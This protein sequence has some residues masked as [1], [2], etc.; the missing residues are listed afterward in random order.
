M[1]SENI[2]RRATFNP[3]VCT[4]W[5][6]SFTIV[7]TVIVVGIPFLLLWIP[8]SLYFTKR[9]LDRME[10]ILT[11]RDLKVNKGL[12]VRV[13]K[14]IPLEKITD[15]GMV[16][17]PLMRYFGI[18]R[19]SVETAGQSLEGSLVS[20][21]GIVDVEDFREAVLNQRDRIRDKP[22]PSVSPPEQSVQGDSGLLRDISATL[23]RIEK[24]LEKQD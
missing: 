16:Q 19:L 8:L 1:S 3:K 21:T 24:L 4:Y 12:F 15:M 5:I 2:I 22:G 23:V 17:G 11:E 7:L 18:H 14:T 13:E 10:C 6:L 20:L 9:Y